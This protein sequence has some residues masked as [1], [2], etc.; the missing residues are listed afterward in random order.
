MHAC[1][2]AY[3]CVCVFDRF[4]FQYLIRFFHFI[5]FLREYKMIGGAQMNSNK[6]RSVHVAEWLGY[7]KHTFKSVQNAYKSERTA[8]YN[9]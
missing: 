6:K 2:H 5:S 3:V 4:Y 8:F 1:M 9:I 7:R